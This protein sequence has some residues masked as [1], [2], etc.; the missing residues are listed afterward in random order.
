MAQGD[1]LDLHTEHETDVRAVSD[2]FQLPANGAFRYS[3]S[4]SP[5]AAPA[6]PALTRRDFVGRVLLQQ[7]EERIAIQS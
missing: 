6:T 1:I 5:Y 7:C 2:S 4:K 3:V